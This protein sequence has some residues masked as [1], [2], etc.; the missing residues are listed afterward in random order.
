MSNDREAV[1]LALEEAAQEIADK[2]A[3]LREVL[4]EDALAEMQALTESEYRE[5]ALVRLSE[6]HQQLDAALGE[7]E[8]VTLYVR[9]DEYEYELIGQI[10]GTYG[11]RWVFIP[12][13]KHMAW[14]EGTAV[15]VRR[16][17]R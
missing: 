4:R 3:L 5:H 2:M 17:K 15:Y 1:L 9:D 7:T 13:N 16:I 11:G 8:P 6:T 14:P 10:F 12:D